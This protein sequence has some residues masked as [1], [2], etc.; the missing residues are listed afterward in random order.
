M[1][2]LRH[3]SDNR[4]LSGSG[5]EHWYDAQTGAVILNETALPNDQIMTALAD[6]HPEVASLI[7]WQVNTQT[8]ASRQGGIFD[9]DRYVTPQNVFK[10]MRLAYQAAESDDVVSGVLDTTETL[11]FAR[12]DIECDDPDEENIWN[13]IAA[14]LDLDARLRE[15]WRELFTI[16]QFYVVNWWGTKSYKVKGMSSKGVSRK[17]AFNLK[18]PL[19]LSLMD[20]LRI[21]PVGNF[22]F[23]RERLAY[24]A[25][26]SEAYSFMNL[27]AEENTTDPVVTQLLE[28]PYEPDQRER[29][30]LGELG[31]AQNSLFL[32]RDQMVWR[33]TATRAQYERFAKVRMKSVFELL[34]LKEQLRQMDRA[35]LLGGTNFII[36][37]KKG[38][39][40]MPARPAEL[41]QLAGQVRS[42]SRVP[43]IVGDHRI[44]IEIITPKTDLTLKPERYNT[45]DSRIEARLFQMFMTGNY[46]SGTKGD[47]SIKLARVV[48]R[49]L[50]SRRHMI[51]RS[52]E[53]CV[54]LPIMKANPSL[55]SEPKLRFH[56]RHV[57]LDFDP[58]W[59]TILQDLRDRGDVSRESHLD[60]LDFSQEEEARKRA[61]EK[62][63]YDKIFETV[64][65]FSKDTNEQNGA[66]KP[67]AKPAAKTTTTPAKPNKP[68]TTADPRSGGRN[69]GGRRNGGGANPDSKTPNANPQKPKKTPGSSAKAAEEEIEE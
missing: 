1:S 34:D 62:K 15:M 37:V 18:I 40:E 16:S 21:V 60:E 32:M 43:V 46:A 44:A 54:L 9:R 56:P 30:W 2:D 63:T 66:A 50:E 69:A 23:N 58:A 68:K 20:P 4:V 45:I 5:S 35:H 53:K 65:P 36:L 61:M 39:D 64:V 51:R 22:M 67:A 24:I 13:Q 28:K 14:D 29:K 38:S 19:S 49:G 55:T 31:I 57:A 52:I 7:R 10:Q 27:L 17:K 6:Q 41:S 11:A 59:A 8:P 33:H 3:M 25:I 26:Q 47:D 12:V 48:G 42:S